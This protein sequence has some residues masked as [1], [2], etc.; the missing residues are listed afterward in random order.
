MKLPRRLMV[1]VVVTA[2]LACVGPAGPQGPQGPA[3]GAGPQGMQGLQGIPGTPGANG[4]AGTPGTTGMTGP[5]GLPGVAPTGSVVAFAGSNPPSGWYLCDGS[6]KDRVA[7]AALFAVI[8]TRYG[9][10][11]GGSTFSL[12]DLSGRSLMGA[13][14]GAGLTP[15]TVGQT[16]GEEMHAVTV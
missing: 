16:F 6:S 15:R 2:G 5:Q 7:D 14:T 13:G 12:P 4:D 8:G 3:G 10:G 11:S 9:N 1:A